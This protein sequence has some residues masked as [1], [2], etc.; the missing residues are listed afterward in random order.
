MNCYAAEA[1]GDSGPI[2]SWASGVLYDNVRI[3]GGGLNLENRWIVPPGA[4]WSAANCVLWQCRAATMR[5]LPPA[6][7]Q[8]LG[9]RLL[10]RFLRRRHVRGPQRLCP[11]A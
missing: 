10:G 11:A 2:E 9:D 4:G 7:G 5:L 8:Q 6:D 3:D 1:L